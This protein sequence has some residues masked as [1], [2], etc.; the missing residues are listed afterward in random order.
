[1]FMKKI[2][3]LPFILLSL[4]IA[5]CNSDKKTAAETTTTDAT[6]TGGQEAVKDDET[7][8]QMLPFLL[9]SILGP[10]VCSHS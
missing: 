4:F 8:F 2:I 6:V 1:M 7:V 9:A 3:I 10:A 5:S